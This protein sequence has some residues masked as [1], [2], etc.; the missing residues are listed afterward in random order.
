LSV[1]G[2]STGEEECDQPD[3]EINGI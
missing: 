3:H 1:P 2:V